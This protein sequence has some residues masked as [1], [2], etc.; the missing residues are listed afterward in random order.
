MKILTISTLLVLP[1]L[2]V[3]CASYRIQPISGTEVARWGDSQTPLKEGY[4]FYQP[5]LYFTATIALETAK[6]KDGKEQTKESVSVAPLY[7]PNYQ[8]P[9]RLTTRNVLAKADF[10]FDWENGWKL[11]RLSDK[12]DNSMVAA[13]LAGELKTLLSAAGLPVTKSVGAPRSRVVLYRPNFD[14]KTGYFI[15]FEEAGVLELPTLA[16]E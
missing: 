16:H 12:S 14:K 3:G 15:G 10:G 13:T 4:I 8:K 2:P 11:T 6:D 9:Y 7:L 5:E 1:L